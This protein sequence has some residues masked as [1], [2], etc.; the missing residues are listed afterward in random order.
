MAAVPS[1]LLRR[2]AGGALREVFS[3]PAPTL[4]AL[5][6]AGDAGLFGPRSVTWKLHAHPSALVGGIR[7]LIVQTL[8]PLAMAGVAQHSDYRSDPLGRLQRTSAFVAAT[9]YGST[10]QAEQAVAAVRRI[11]KSVRGLAPDGRRYDANDPA[12][13]AW[14]HHVEVES[15]LLAYRRVGPGLSDADADRY[16]GEMARVG[17]LFGA[18]PLFTKAAPLQQWLL[19]HPEVRATSEARDAVRF[20]AGLPLPLVARPAYAVFFGAAASLVPWRWRLQLR[21]LLPGP[22]SGRLVS[23]P[24]ARALIAAMGWVLGP[25]PAMTNADARVRAWPA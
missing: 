15:F 16:V 12:L 25:S 3:A 17:E 11:H 18:R 23:E 9:T 10:A 7:S 20:L 6:G 5:T 8:H 4:R 14:V 1:D 19:H 13:L 21:L 22:V 2:A 24:A